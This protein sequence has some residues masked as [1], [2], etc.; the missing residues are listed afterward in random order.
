MSAPRTNQP[1]AL[2]RA[3]LG[4]RLALVAIVFGV[5]LLFA[6]LMLGA[7]QLPSLQCQFVSA[8]FDGELFVEDPERLWRLSPTCEKFEVNEVGLRGWWPEGPAPEGELRILCVGDSC[9]FGT[10]V[11]YDETYGVVLA[12]TLSNSRLGMTARAVLLALPGYSTYQDLVLLRQRAAEL[13]PDLVVLY[14]GAWNDY[15]PAWLRTDREWGDVTKHGVPSRLVELFRRAYWSSRHDD[16]AQLVQDYQDGEAPPLLRVPLAEYRANLEALIATVEDAGAQPLVVL[17]AFPERTLARFPTGGRYL[18][19][20]RDVVAQTGVPFVDATAVVERFEADQDIR[21]PADASALT[22][23]D[24]I[25]PSGIG[26]GLIARAISAEL[27]SIGWPG[28]AT[29]ASSEL[30]PPEVRCEVADGV[31]NVTWGAVAGAEGYSIYFEELVTGKIGAFDC[32]GDTT[33]Q[34]SLRAP[35][36]FRFCVQAHRWGSQGPCSETITVGG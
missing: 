31:A 29:A 9:T 21:E 34:M 2:R 10:G 32:G 28:Q 5:S 6:E 13:Q 36:K 3:P 4:L 12:R 8:T 25:H 15:L 11:R 17:P 19:V 35:L 30:T 33:F 14:C 1:T 16:P 26:H 24:W 22:Y 7:L 23:T 18:E 20:T 27:E